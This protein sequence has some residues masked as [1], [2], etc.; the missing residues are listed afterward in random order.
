VVDYKEYRA[1]VYL[2]IAWSPQEQKDTYWYEGILV[3]YIS[4]EA[5]RRDKFLSRGGDY[6]GI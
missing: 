2:G 1:R 6:F 4:D 5:V 3:L